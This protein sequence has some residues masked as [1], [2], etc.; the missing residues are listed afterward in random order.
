MRER[1][2]KKKNH[3]TE[4]ISFTRNSQIPNLSLP[5]DTGKPS[6]LADI[7][8]NVYFTS[9]QAS[10]ATHSQGTTS[11]VTF[12]RRRKPSKVRCPNFLPPKQ[13]NLAALASTQWK[14][15]LS[16]Q[17][18]YVRVGWIFYHPSGALLHHRDL[19]LPPP[20]LSFYCDVSI[21]I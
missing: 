10:Y 9:S 8:N 15:C 21:S 5:L 13:I 7:L 12:P 19:L 3:K 18:S 1:G 11:H 4:Q 14:R 17:G 20:F 2:R 6:V 16:S